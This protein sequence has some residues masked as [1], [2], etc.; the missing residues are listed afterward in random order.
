MKLIID[1]PEL[2]Y[3]CAK[4]RWMRGN[5]AHQMDYYISKGVPFYGTTNG[6]VIQ[7]L[8]PEIE[9]VEIYNSRHRFFLKG[10]ES[11]IF[12]LKAEVKWWNALYK[13]GE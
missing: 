1:I 3:E 6:E 7:A 10:K 9:L 12:D 13:K 4:Q 2:D 11:T 5:D 8:F